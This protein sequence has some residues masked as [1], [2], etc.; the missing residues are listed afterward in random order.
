MRTSFILN[1]DMIT[2]ELKQFLTECNVLKQ[3]SRSI[4]ARPVLCI[5]GTVICIL[6][7]TGYPKNFQKVFLILHCYQ[8]QERFLKT[9]YETKLIRKKIVNLIYRIISQKHEIIL[10][11]RMNLIMVK[12]IE[13]ISTLIVTN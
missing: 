9:I 7:N 6:G 12:T 8:V 13:E 2:Q 4:P 11:I 3:F 1:Q 10:Q 5:V